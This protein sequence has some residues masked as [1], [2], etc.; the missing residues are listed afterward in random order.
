MREKDWKTKIRLF[1]V[2]KCS[3]NPLF[4]IWCSDNSSILEHWTKFNISYLL[5]HPTLW[6]VWILNVQVIKTQTEIMLLLSK[7]LQQKSEMFSLD[8][9]TCPRK[10]CSNPYYDEGRCTLYTWWF[11]MK[12]LFYSFSFSSMSTHASSNVHG[13]CLSFDQNEKWW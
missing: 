12:C 1:Y 6:F 10:V 4:C 3:L 8:Y 9:D 5:L 7:Q 13:Y 11:C 2:E